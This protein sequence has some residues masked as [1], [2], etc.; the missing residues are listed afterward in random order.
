MSRGF[1]PAD[2]VEVFN[3]NGLP[4]LNTLNALEN[5]RGYWVKADMEGTGMLEEGEGAPN[6]AFMRC[7]MA[8]PTCLPGHLEI[9]DDRGRMVGQAQGV[10]KPD[11]FG[12]RP[13]MEGHLASQKAAC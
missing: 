4:W 10:M 11:G 5:S 13:C 12:P 1:S 2:G 9:L 7:S 3:P 6:P 8:E